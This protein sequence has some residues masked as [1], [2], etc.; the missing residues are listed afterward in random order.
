MDLLINSQRNK[1][2]Y[3]PKNM[4]LLSVSLGTV[5]KR[6]FCSILKCGRGLR[7]NITFTDYVKNSFELGNLISEL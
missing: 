6:P 5:D 4:K 3:S 2:A 7:S 1:Q